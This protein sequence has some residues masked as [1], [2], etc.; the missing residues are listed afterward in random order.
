MLI[1]QKQ[2]NEWK[3]EQTIWNRWVLSWRFNAETAA[4][5]VSY[6]DRRTAGMQSV[7]GTVSVEDGAEGL[8]GAHI[9]DG[10]HQVAERVCLQTA[11]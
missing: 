1:R 9:A 6:G 8:L 11:S 2:T 5:S 7:L 3:T 4:R 10:R